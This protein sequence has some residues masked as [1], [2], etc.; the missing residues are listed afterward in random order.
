[1]DTLTHLLR[2]SAPRAGTLFLLIALGLPPAGCSQL[3]P[4]ADGDA[5]RSAAAQPDDHL[6]WWREARFGMFI[7]WG[8]VSL[9]GT[10]IGW[11]RAGERRGTGGTGTIPPEVYDALY[12]EFNPVNFDAD[13]WVR[14]ARDA[15]MKYLVFTT[16]HHDGFANFDSALTDYKITSP[17]SP[18]GRDITRELAEACHRAGMP[19][20][21]YHSQ[22]D[23]YHP[24]FRTENHHRYLDYLHGQVRELC[25]QYG[26]VSVMWFDGL[27]GTAEDWNA[28]PLLEMIRS[29]QPGVII[30]NRCGLPADYD[31]P[32][33]V[34]GG[35]QADRAWET[36][37]TIGTQWSW[38]PDDRIKSLRE[39]LQTLVRVV[40]GDG[41]FL[42]NVGPMPDGRIEPRQ[43]E[44]L[45]Q[46]GE[47]LNL[48]GESVYGT[49][50]GPFKWNLCGPAPCVSTHRDNRVYLHVLEWESET[51]SLPPIN[52]NVLRSSLLTGGD[53]EV[54]QYAGG[55][56]INVPPQDRQD[57]ATIVVLELDGPAEG[58]PPTGIYPGIP[59]RVVSA[60]A[61]NVFENRPEFAPQ[62][63]FDDDVT[64]RWATDSDTREAWIAADLGEPVMID[65]M[66]IC[67]AFGS[68]VR[69]FE[70]QYRT[71]NDWETAWRGTTISGAGLVQFAPVTARHVRFRI[72]DATKGPTFP[73]IRIFSPAGR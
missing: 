32:E 69:Q 17:E 66:A 13:E 11:S 18:F 44:R 34:I 7:H 36:C 31:T 22:P 25:T 68:R 71:D 42:F 58:I 57:I 62:K 53:V 14:I 49:R 40:G 24:D 8:P 1:M 30:N 61:S 21:F 6:R 47:W 60:E 33:Q 55:I 46:M 52:R 29:L 28:E 16:K 37:M 65:S 10:E 56:T 43:A 15:G 73:E 3:R 5:R 19:I 51:L 26:Q 9:K 72:L 12:R 35:F 54:R 4:S 70:I 64:T 50:G 41:N 63:A 39:C 59:V 48:Y 23:W 38:K 45:R 27:G 20:G 2:V 67:E